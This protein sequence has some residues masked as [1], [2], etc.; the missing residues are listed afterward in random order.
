MVLSVIPIAATREQILKVWYEIDERKKLLA[1]SGSESGRIQSEIYSFQTQLNDLIYQCNL[2]RINDA[3]DKLDS[4]ILI[5]NV[6]RDQTLAPA[7]RKIRSRGTVVGIVDSDG[8][9]VYETDGDGNPKQL[10][11]HGKPVFKRDHY[12]KIKLDNDGQPIPVLVPKSK[13]AKGD[14]I[15]GQLHKESFLGAIKLVKKE[16]SGK[17][18]RDEEGKLEFEDV[19]Y[20][21]REDL[22]FKKNAQSPGFTSL[23]DLKKQIVDQHLYAMI[24]TQS[25]AA[26]GFKEALAQGI[27]MI[28]KNGNRVNKI[29][30]VRIFVRSSN[31]LALKKQTYVSNK[32][33]K[34][35]ENRDHKLSYWA[36]N[37]ERPYYAM[38]ELKGKLIPESYTLKQVADLTA[39]SLLPV[40]SFEDL[41]EVTKENGAELRFTLHK[42]LRV[43]FLKE[44]KETYSSLPDY[45]VNS[46]YKVEG[47][48]DDNRISFKHHLISEDNKGLKAEMKLRELPDAGATSID[49]ENPIPLLRLNIHMK[50][51]GVQA[52][53]YAIEGRHFLVN[54][55]G[56]I[57]WKA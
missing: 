12:G 44:P 49:F 45:Y 41:L 47:I 8:K 39:K 46:L 37:K 50:P 31:P 42:G 26:G 19:R 40:K 36:D 27:W 9:P 57:D 6:S 15:R 7:K 53:N 25:K 43:I 48:E 10:L 3:I 5:N 1:D 18:K 56:Q 16:E 33:L 13:L 52:F 29:R 51:K 22:V 17:W 11:Q 28:G 4:Q 2:P 55:D 34:I 30:H 32:P 24:E 21:I 20:V 38:Y 23:E 35:L 54:P 14:I